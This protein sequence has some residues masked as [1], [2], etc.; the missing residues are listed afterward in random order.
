MVTFLSVPGGLGLV[1]PLSSSRA[2]LLGLVWAEI[3]QV[4]VGVV[5]VGVPELRVRVVPSKTPPPPQPAKVLPA[6]KVTSMVPVP[7][8]ESPPVALVLKLTTYWVRAPA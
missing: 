7:V 6:G 4:L 3:V 5:L 1:T 8:L 2:V